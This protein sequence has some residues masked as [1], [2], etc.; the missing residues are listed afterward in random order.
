MDLGYAEDCDNEV[1]NEF[2]LFPS[3]DVVSE[4]TNSTKTS[5]LKDSKIEHS[6]I[7]LFDA[8]GLSTPFP[9]KLNIYLVK[10]IYASSKMTQC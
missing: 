2:N 5:F 1:F 3:E 8:F 9:R 7:D 6:A 4:K 10:V